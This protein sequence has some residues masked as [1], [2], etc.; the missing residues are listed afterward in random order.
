MMASCGFRSVYA[1]S[2]FHDVEIQLQNT[3]FVQRQFQ[4]AGHDGFLDFTQN[5]TLRAEP[6]IFCELLGDGAAP[7]RKAA[8]LQIPF[9]SVAHGAEIE[10]VVFPEGVVFRND[11]GLAQVGRYTVQRNPDPAY[12]HVLVSLF[13]FF[14]APFI[15]TISDQRGCLRIGEGQPAYRRPDKITADIQRAQENKTEEQPPQQTEAAPSGGE[16]LFHA[17]E[18]DCRPQSGGITE[19]AGKRLTEKHPIAPAR[20]SR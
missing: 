8:L 4:T 20:L 11:H 17:H 6:E 16:R 2:P 9:Q 10:T 3:V 1:V 7:G 12:R 13:S 19:L 5:G 15:L 14:S 18:A